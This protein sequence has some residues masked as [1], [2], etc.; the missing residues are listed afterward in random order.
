MRS[1]DDVRIDIIFVVCLSMVLFGGW[2][3][4]GFS[5]IWVSSDHDEILDLA[6]KNG[7]QIH[8]RSVETSTDGSSS[9]EAI[10]EFLIS[11]P[12][13]PYSHFWCR[14]WLVVYI[15]MSCVV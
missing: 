6:G 13:R 1:V 10:N 7:A 2:I 12:G 8:R 9:L 5:S 15:W 14:W 11:H 3:V 4:T